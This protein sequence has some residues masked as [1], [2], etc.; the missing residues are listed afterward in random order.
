M[1][2]DLL[3]V[4]NELRPGESFGF[5][6]GL[7]ETLSNVSWLSQTT[8]TQTQYDQLEDTSNLVYNEELNIYTVMPFTIPKEQEC[9]DYWN[10]TLKNKNAFTNLRHKRNTLLDKTD[11]Y[12]VADFPHPT[13]E[14]RQAWLDY[15]QALRDLP[16]ITTDP[17]NPVWPQ[18]PN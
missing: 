1:Y 12:I 13:E 14:V 15:R 6:N 7:L 8:Y 5:D 3:K 2:M 17:S 10:T 18:A 11:K 9:L 4:L 16:A